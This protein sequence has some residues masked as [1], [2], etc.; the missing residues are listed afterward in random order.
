MSVNNNEHPWGRFL[1]FNALCA[2]T[3]SVSVTLEGGRSKRL[4]K[5]WAGIQS[6]ALN[7]YGT[8]RKVRRK[9]LG[10]LKEGNWPYPDLYKRM[11]RRGSRKSEVRVWLLEPSAVLNTAGR[12]QG[13]PARLDGEGRVLGAGSEQQV[14]EKSCHQDE[15]GQ[16]LPTDDWEQLRP[17]CT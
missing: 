10:W 7:H 16:F 11:R 8:V 17:L 2:Q 15:K 9:G 14:G 12:P 5:S 4:L 6:C 13:Q 1:A 3:R